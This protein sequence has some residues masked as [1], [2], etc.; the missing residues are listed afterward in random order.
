[1][2]EAMNMPCQDQVLYS[3]R[4]A[5]LVLALLMAG[6]VRFTYDETSTPALYVAPLPTST[7]TLAGTLLPVGTQPSPSSEATPTAALAVQGPAVL[8]INPPVVNLAVGETCL[9]Q[10]WLDNVEGLQS[11]ELQ[12]GFDPRYVRIEDADP[13]A[14]GVQVGAGIIPMPTDVVQ[15]EVDDDAGLI[16]YHAAQAPGN[17]VSGSGMVASM[18]AR[19]LADGGSPLSLGVAHLRG[20]EGQLLPAPRLVDGLVVV[21]TGEG[22]PEPSPM[23]TYPVSTSPAPTAD[24]YHTVQ[25]GENLFRIALR[26]GTSVDAIVAANNL[27]DPHSISAGQRL[28]IPASSTAGAQTYVVQAGDTLFSIASRFGTTVEALAALN[29]LAPPYALAVGQELT[30]CRP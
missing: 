9:V 21:G 2:T 22:L 29:G 25:A 13:E 26:Y 28:R 15:N 11:I 6:C 20:S 12:I 30:I 27:S 10:V 17:P 5:L 16:S 19:A 4:V 3:Q 18:T 23:P 14:E 7:P 1:M 24:V 8:R